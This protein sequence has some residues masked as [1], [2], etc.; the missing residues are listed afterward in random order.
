MLESDEAVALALPRGLVEDDDGLLELAVG[1]E[2][3]AEAVVG[4]VPAEAADEELAAGGVGVGDGAGGG[5]E[6]GVAEQGVLEEVEELV[7]GEALEHPAA[8]VA[9]EGG[10]GIGGVRRRHAVVVHLPLL[11][12]IQAT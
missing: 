3:G 2:E 5:A 9:G 8:L 7:L 12:E 6:V 11:R 10:A 4:G 1:G